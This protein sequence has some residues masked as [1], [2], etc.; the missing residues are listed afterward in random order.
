[1]QL[2][3]IQVTQSHLLGVLLFDYVYVKIKYKHSQI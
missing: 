3:I 2:T 1:V